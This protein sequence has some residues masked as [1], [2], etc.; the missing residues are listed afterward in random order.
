MRFP[1]ILCTI[2]LV[3]GAITGCA[4]READTPVTGGDTTF[5]VQITPPGGAPVTI[6]LTPDP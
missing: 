1:S 5:P 6:E 4:G 2:P 3:F